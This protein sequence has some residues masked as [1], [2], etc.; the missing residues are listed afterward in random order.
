M[1]DIGGLV[2][3]GCYLVSEPKDAWGPG[4]WGEKSVLGIKLYLFG[5]GHF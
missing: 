3:T 5:F 4:L 1:S 2:S